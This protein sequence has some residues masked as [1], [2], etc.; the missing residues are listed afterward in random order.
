MYKMMD[1]QLSNCFLL[2]FMVFISACGH[3]ERT[4]RLEADEVIPV[5]VIPLASRDTAQVIRATGTFTTDDETL[6]AFKNG[7]VIQ[8]ITVKEGEGFR[9][10]QVLA[11]VEQTEINT[12]VRQ[13]QLGL[14][15]AERDYRRA[16]QL[17]RDSVATR[18][19]LENAET[20]FEAAKQDVERA[21]YNQR[22]TDIRAPFDGYVLQRP[23]NTGQ[24][25]GPGTPVLVVGSTGQNGWLLKVGV[26]DRQWA[27]IKVGDHA[28]IMVDAIQG[29]HLPAV[30][31][32]KSEGIDPQAGTFTVYLKLGGEGTP[33]LASGMFGKAEIRQSTETGAWFV[34]YEA[35]LDGDAGTGYVFVTDDGQTVRRIPVEIGEIQRDY[36]VVTGG[37]ENAGSLIVSGSPYLR[38]G[39]KI[40]VK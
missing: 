15:K 7:G 12:A 28:D 32:R 21:D 24:V 22:E 38:D 33:A 23:A 11:S 19:Q 20:A 10:G 27:S 17:Y 25:V 37:L 6:L 31:H 35:L 40:T 30:V 34:P 1:M 4:G 36:I 2:A 29:S 5:K 3:E 16:Q 8:Q 14:E 39:S 13:A 26:S 9:K 18:E